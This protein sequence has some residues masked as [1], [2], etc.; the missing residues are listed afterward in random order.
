VAL[1]AR[2]PIQD[3]Y[4]AGFGFVAS[5]GGFSVLVSLHRFGG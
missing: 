2:E 1:A 3:R 5:E 4:S